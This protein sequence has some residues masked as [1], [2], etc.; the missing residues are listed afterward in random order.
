M[1]DPRAEIHLGANIADNVTIGPWSIIEKDVTI[2]EGT[3]IGP[4]VV[5][6]GPTKIGKDNHIFQFASI[7][8]APQDKKYA[9]EA[10]VLEIGDR[11]II[12]EFATL[13]RGTVQGGGITKVGNDNLFMSYTHVA[14]DCIVGNN[15][16]FAN[17]AGLA[18]H[19]I[20]EDWVTLAGYAAVHQFCTIGMHSFIGGSKV[21]QDVLPFL[22]IAGEENPKPYGLNTVGLRRRGFSD[23]TIS[24]L[25]KAYRFIFRD[26]LSTEEMLSELKALVPSCPEVQLFLTAIEKST[27]GFLR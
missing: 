11:N 27:R 2:G 9:N 1:I 16:I 12:R 15:V 18:G 7:G 4:H 13:N 21:K 26:E 19:V 6:Q 8:A 10:T 20:I 22:M 5:I 17:Y 3:V 24:K 23:E 25:K 14:H